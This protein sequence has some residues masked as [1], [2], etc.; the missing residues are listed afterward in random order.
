MIG[1]YEFW[2]PGLE[3]IYKNKSS[4]LSIGIT[5]YFLYFGQHFNFDFD[6]ILK[7][8]FKIEEDKK[9]EDLLKNLLK[10]NQDEIL[11][12]EEYFNHPFFKQYEY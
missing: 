11:T 5:I 2:I 8:N 10:E 12:W 9:L 4:L 3:N 7:G 6:E 1:T